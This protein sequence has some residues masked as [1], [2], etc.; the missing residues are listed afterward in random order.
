MTDM[1]ILVW[2][3]VS[4]RGWHEWS[5]ADYCSCSI[6]FQHRNSD[7]DRKFISSDIH[8]CHDEAVVSLKGRMCIGSAFTRVTS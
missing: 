2:R 6:K 3:F 1:M 5:V 4:K 8:E 7:L